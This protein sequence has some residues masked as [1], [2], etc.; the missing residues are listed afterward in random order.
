MPSGTE[1]DLIVE[2]GEERIGYEFKCSASVSRSDVAG[3]RAGLADGVI[4]RG[5]AVSAGSR[6]YPLT[7]EIEAIPAETLLGDALVN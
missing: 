1:I 3:L 5:M 6:R 4:T 7:D 2:Y